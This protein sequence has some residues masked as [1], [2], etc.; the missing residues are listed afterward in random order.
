MTTASAVACNAIAV[1]IPD[2]PGD[3]RLQVAA[4]FRK[5]LYVGVVSPAE[6]SD[7][8]GTARILRYY[9]GAE[10]WEVVCETPVATPNWPRQRARKKF[11]LEL[12]WRAMT[13]VPGGDGHEVL[14]LSLLCPRH[15]RLFYSQDGDRFEVLPAG[16]QQ[17]PFG[18]LHGFQGWVFGALAGAMSD[19]I[20]EKNA[21][22]GLLYACRDP[23]TTTWALANAPGFGDPHNQVIHGLQVFHGWLYAAAGNPFAGFQL[24]RT[25]ARSDP[26]FDWEKVLDRGAQRY[27]FNT[28]IAAMAVFR[29]A[30][31]LGTGVPMGEHSLEDAAGCELIRVL[32]DGRWE[33]V[34]GQPRFSPI[35]LQVPASAHGPGFDDPA[36]T[37]LASLASSGDALYAVTLA[38][39]PEGVSGFQ[40][41]SGTDGESW[42]RIAVPN[43]GRSAIGLPRALIALPKFLLVAGN[44]YSDKTD[45]PPEPFVW[46][47]RSER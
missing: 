40:L 34:M 10:R 38:R 16:N 36:Q 33:L 19:G 12:G 31:Y 9:P 28:A 3:Q 15:P 11:P 6:D 42:R 41:W 4:F 45:G 21:G 18:A 35:G 30:L 29:D 24:W 46:F 20:A 25:Q 43:D 37:A 8:P 26:P 22:G 23:R 5:R 14:C 1:S 27:T 17:Q 2:A 39:S 47:G 7:A 13:V 44:G 32:P